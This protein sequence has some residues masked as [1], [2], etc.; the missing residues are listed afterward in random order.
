MLHPSA[1]SQPAATS[2]LIFQQQLLSLNDLLH[3]SHKIYDRALQH[4][5]EFSIHY[6]HSPL[7]ITIPEA[8]VALYASYAHNKNWAHSTIASQLSAIAY[9]H[10]MQGFTDPTKNILVRKV[11]HDIARLTPSYGI[12][13]PITEAILT[14]L[15][16]ALNYLLNFNYERKL[17]QA[18][19]TTAFYCLARTGEWVNYSGEQLDNLVQLL[20]LTFEKSGDEFLHFFLTFRT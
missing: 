3:A 13:L 14:R 19:C 9:I 11:I 2:P 15:C 17:F 7:Q 10:T 8:N 4:F 20:N 18:M 16:D 6:L 1:D 5:N 12:R